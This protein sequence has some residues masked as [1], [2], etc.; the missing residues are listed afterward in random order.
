MGKCK[1]HVRKLTLVPGAL[2]DAG[3]DEG[4]ADDEDE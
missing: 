4:E 2:G 1:V 3:G